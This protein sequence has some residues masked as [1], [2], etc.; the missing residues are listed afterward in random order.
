MGSSGGRERVHLCCD[1]S[2]E[3]GEKLGQLKE[4]KP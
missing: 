1:W 4:K 3:N 2:E